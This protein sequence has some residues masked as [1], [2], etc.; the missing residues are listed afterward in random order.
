MDSPFLTSVVGVLAPVLGGV[1]TVFMTRWLGR[2]DPFRTSFH[3]RRVDALL[4]LTSRISEIVALGPSVIQKSPGS[5]GWEQVRAQCRRAT[6]LLVGNIV[7][8]PDSVVEQGWRVLSL[9]S[10][11]P[12]NRRTA[13][14]LSLS[15][16]AFHNECRKS[17]GYRPLSKE[18]KRM[19]EVASG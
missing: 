4:E 10:D 17:I 13:G 5:A 8:L 11:P 15:L 14:E 19:L 2:R 1:L 16:W 18:L 7:L 12:E 3:E 6:A 9:L